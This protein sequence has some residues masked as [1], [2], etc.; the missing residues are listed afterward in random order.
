MG[1]DMKAAEPQSAPIDPDQVQVV[2]GL[3]LIE[4]ATKL[5]DSA[6]GLVKQKKYPEAIHMYE[7]GIERL[8]TADGHPMMRD[9][10]EQIVKLKSVLYGNVAQCL[11]SQELYRRAITAV[12][13]ALEL[14]EENVKNL[15]RRSQ[16]RE[17]LK[18]WK[19]ALEDSE[20]LQALGGGS[21][22]KEALDARLEKL[23]CKLQAEEEEKAREAAES[24]DDGDIDLVALKD[25]F[26]AV[27][28]KYDLKDGEAA[29]ELADWLTSGEW[30]IT[31]KKV[32]DRWHMEYADAA[33]FLAWI[34]KG[35]EFKMASCAAADRAGVA[36]TEPS[37]D[38]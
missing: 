38:V 10:V 30:N 29:G 37:L 23:R 22:S 25:K 34:S 4:D 2:D 21:L 20:K 7:L 3:P 18:E 13:S 15:Y 6:N 16:A 1:V 32:A 31:V 33:S 27:V 36:S 12:N 24:D 8:D 11:L 35:L 19:S 17:A 14:D 26:D 5:K 28:E 9:E